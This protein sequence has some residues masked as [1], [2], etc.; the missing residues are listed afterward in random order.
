MVKE[1]VIEGFFI[2]VAS[3]FRDGHLGHPFAFV[4][5]V[6]VIALTIENLDVKS[7]FTVRDEYIA[8]IALGLGTV[9]YRIPLLPNKRSSLE[10]F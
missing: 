1:W 10:I 3:F 5:G 7:F 6:E 8:F 4:Y 9:S 2:G